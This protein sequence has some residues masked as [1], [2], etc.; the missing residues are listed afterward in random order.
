MLCSTRPASRL[1]IGLRRGSVPFCPSYH[2]IFRSI[3]VRPPPKHSLLLGSLGVL[4][5]RWWRAV[6]GPYDLCDVLILPCVFPV[7]FFFAPIFKR[8][9]ATNP[10]IMGAASLCPPL[11][12]SPPLP[13]RL[14]SF[15]VP[16][17]LWDLPRAC[18]LA[19][20]ATLNRCV[21]DLARSAHE[22]FLLSASIYGPAF[23]HQTSLCHAHLLRNCPPL[24]EAQV[25]GD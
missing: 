3:S 23:E 17:P 4:C 2:Y 9:G 24:H 5:G 10:L 18:W 6:P 12:R 20:T 1:T 19:V 15:H 13:S 11:P 22:L 25:R 7:F 21:A 16:A 8:R 14:L